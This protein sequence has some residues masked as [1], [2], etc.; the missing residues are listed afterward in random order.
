MHFLYGIVGTLS[1]KAPKRGLLAKKW[2]LI[3][4]FNLSKYLVLMVH[5]FEKISMIMKADDQGHR[6]LLLW[7]FPV[8]LHVVAIIVKS[9][10]KAVIK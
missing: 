2:Q 5:A 6:L 8:K 10:Y 3:K 4:I 9:I 1:K 7:F